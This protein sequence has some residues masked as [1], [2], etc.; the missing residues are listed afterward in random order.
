MASYFSWIQHHTEAL[1]TR[2]LERIARDKA[3]R[4]QKKSLKG[5]LLSWLDAIVFAVIFVLIINQYL[6]QLFMIPSPSMV[7]TLLIKDRVFV[8]K[9]S[10]GVELYPGGKKIFD[11]RIPL[12]DDV[13][14][15]YNP[16]YESKGPFFDV[17]S[18][19]VYMATFSLLNIDVDE[20]G[21]MRERLYVKRAAAL[22]GDTIR[23]KQGT[24]YI[25]G[26]GEYQFIDD[27][28]FR[29]ENGLSQAPHQ[30]LDS[31][32]YP[33]FEAYGSLLAYQEK[34]LTTVVPRHL[35]QT[36]QR[37]SN[38]QGVIDYYEVE[39]ARN[40]TLNQI[41]PHDLVQRS[42][43]ARYEQGI[44]VPHGYVLPLGDNRDNSHDGRYFG[45]VS[46]DTVIGRVLFRFWPF[47]RMGIVS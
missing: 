22:G 8:S 26:A 17:L 5:E 10:Y 47:G 3:L 24:A 27:D 13:I 11:T 2:R 40:R 4:S 29:M 37:V 21:N 44:Y 46:H 6:F 14:V 42:H 39:H 7:E 33:G 32:V 23:F 34:Q 9:T 38:Y 43:A 45:P 1:L 18:Q 30:S 36:Y 41:N 35:V 15:F 31:T 16:E 20:D 19:I 28:S 25:S 12:R